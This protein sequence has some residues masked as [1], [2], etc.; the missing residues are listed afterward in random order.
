MAKHQTSQDVLKE[1]ISIMGE[2]LGIL[3]NAL[4]NESL[5]LM[6]IWKEYIEIYGTKESRVKLVNEAAPFFFYTVQR[7]LWDNT[8]LGICRITDPPETLGKRNVTFQAIPNFITD[9]PLKATIDDL[10]KGLLEKSGFCRDWRN[11]RISHNDYILKTNPTVKPLEP[12]SVEKVNKVF[13]GIERLINQIQLHYL[14]STLLFDFIEAHRGA[15]SLLYVIDD[16]L[17]REKEKMERRKAGIMSPE[18]QR[19]RDI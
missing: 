16:G 12:A 8:L 13:E 7:T 9:E 2:D 5:W 15:R 11:R 1:H 18:D 6:Y 3:F 4:Y 14:G 10:V 17:K 19:V